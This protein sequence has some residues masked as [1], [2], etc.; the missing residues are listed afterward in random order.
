MFLLA[1]PV[2]AILVEDF[3]GHPAGSVV[4]G[5]MPGGGTAPGTIFSDITVS[6]IANDAPHAVIIFDSANPTGGDFDLGTPNEDFGGPGIGHGGQMGMPGENSIPYGNLLIIAENINDS[7]GDGLVDAPNDDA[8]GGTIIFDFDYVV[9]LQYMVIVDIDA[10]S[11]TY[12]THE[13]GIFIGGDSGSDLGNNS[14]QVIDLT[15]FFSVDRLVVNFSSSGAI[16]ELGYQ[17]ASVPAAQTTWGS[18]KSL[19]K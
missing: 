16:A 15:P 11:V 14:I 5:D 9:D 7:D 12:E 18:V 17:E 6:V 10:E 13:F 3:G 19:Y 2:H 8:N 4:A 1:I